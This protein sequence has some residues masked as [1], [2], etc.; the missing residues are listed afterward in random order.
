MIERLWRT[1]KYEEVFLRDY[2]HLFAARESLGDYFEFYN[3]ER[4]PSS[5]AGKTP[6]AVYREGRARIREAG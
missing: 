4:R 3:G 5:L 6:S 2:A 1:V